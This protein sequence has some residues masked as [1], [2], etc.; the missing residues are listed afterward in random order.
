M[1]S[2]AAVSARSPADTEF[3]DIMRTQ[4]KRFPSS[5]Y[6]ELP[7]GD[8]MREKRARVKMSAW[9]DTETGISF[10]SLCLP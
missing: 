3:G 9:M 6:S 1:S 4:K 5:L 7:L 8:Y 2:L 10:A